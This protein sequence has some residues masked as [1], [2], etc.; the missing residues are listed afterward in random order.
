MKKLVVGAF[1]ALSASFLYG[2]GIISV[3]VS[4]S[5]QWGQVPANDTM[6]GLAPA[7]GKTWINTTEQGS[8]TSATLR[9]TCECRDG[10]KNELQ[11]LDAVFTASKLNLWSGAGGS[12]GTV[13]KLMEKYYDGNQDGWVTVKIENVPYRQYDLLVY[14]A[15]YASVSCESVKVNGTAYHYDAE[16]GGAVSGNAKWG[17]GD[18]SYCEEGTNVLRVSFLHAQTL[19][20]SCV[21]LCA[22]QVVEN[23]EDPGNP[24]GVISVNFYN[25]S[26]NQM[27]SNKGGECGALAGSMVLAESWNDFTPGD[28]KFVPNGEPLKV[29]DGESFC[30]IPAADSGVTLTCD[31]LGCYLNYNTDDPFLKAHYDAAWTTP[32]VKVS[33]I[34]WEL[35]DVIVYRASNYGDD[36][37][38]VALNGV[39]YT[40]S[41]LLSVTVQGSDPWGQPT[42]EGMS[43]VAKPGVNALRVNGLRGKDLLIDD[44]KTL[45]GHTGKIGGL[46]AIQI[47]K[48][49]PDITTNVVTTSCLNELAKGRTSFTV[50]LEEGGR[51]VVDEPLT[52]NEIC[53]CSVGNIALVSDTPIADDD[54]IYARLDLV[55]VSGKVFHSWLG[56]GS[57]ISVN[58]GAENANKSV[59][60]AG[61]DGYLAG[62]EILKNSWN[63]DNQGSKIEVPLK[64]M[65]GYVLVPTNDS[66][67]SM[68]RANG[69][70][71]GSYYYPTTLQRGWINSADP[72]LAISGI[73]WEFYDVIVYFARDYG[74]T[75]N[76]LAANGKLYTWSNAEDVMVEGGAQWGDRST[77]LVPQL[78]KNALKV[79][80]L[81]GITCL[82]NDNATLKGHTVSYKQ[83]S[84]AGVQIVKRV[85]IEAAGDLTTEEINA[86]TAG[87]DVV[88]VSIPAGKKLV[89]TQPLVCGEVRVGCLG[90]MVLDTDHRIT[91]D[92]DATLAKLDF[93][94]VRGLV[95]RDFKPIGM[96]ISINMNPGS[97]EMSGHALDQSLG[98]D[99]PADSWNNITNAKNEVCG[100]QVWNG[101]T[102]ALIP[103]EESGITMTRSDGSFWYSGNT[104][105]PFMNGIIDGSCPAPG[106]VVSGLPMETYDV[107]V[108]F[109]CA[110]GENGF[111]PV[112][113]NGT[114]YT[115]ANGATVAGGA[116]WGVRSSSR[117]PE[118]GVNAIKVKGVKGS[119]LTINDAATLSGHEPAV[120][121]I[122]AIQIVE[123]VKRVYSNGMTVI[124]R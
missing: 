101:Q 9:L 76:P 1:L 48:R 112:A 10:A 69:G 77:S 124:I 111:N 85:D 99:I 94:A 102:H 72:G 82:L 11:K 33:D 41:D 58:F 38:P 91:G 32:G 18:N 105:R 42:G 39:L 28:D 64:F 45:S 15:G 21:N 96:T 110:Y 51:L 119:T 65:D 29:W 117:A 89:I 8:I 100:L 52:A 31:N 25:G 103:T 55:G 56:N 59:E 6:Y 118:F 20:F 74:D 107:I 61:F 78:G 23:L 122:A 44:S 84:I 97:G 66:C 92:D 63:N 24:K 17:K 53:L 57:S 113:I 7:P 98:G 46:A 2:G 88:Y 70:T 73:P 54:P 49:I 80:G 3:N 79:E 121:A 5:G 90:D 114:L 27:V 26:D 50:V 4:E 13:Q 62:A 95:F 87:K 22:F 115:Y 36:F 71:Y 34:P 43:R 120:G 109:A 30:T 108:Y 12:Q 104:T 60:G 14:M 123:P 40:W 116:A 35:Y 106:I 86:R 16:A 81:F 37:N 47:V 19:E 93:S 67:V 68:T 75:F 83:G